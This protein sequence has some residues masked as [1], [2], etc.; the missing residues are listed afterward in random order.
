MFLNEKNLVLSA[1]FSLEN[2]FFPFKKHS[3]R[4]ICFSLLPLT[5]TKAVSGKV[6]SGFQVT[7]CY[8]H[9]I[10]KEFKIKPG[11]M[12]GYRH[13]L[14]KIFL[15]TEEIKVRLEIEPVPGPECVKWCPRVS[16]GRC[17]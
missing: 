1:K 9:P 8:L 6:G 3:E 13:W 7:Q 15:C 12:E 17:P 4:Q 2:F 5:K 16:S 14:P 10:E 11:L